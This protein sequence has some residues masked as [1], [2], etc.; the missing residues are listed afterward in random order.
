MRWYPNV[1][2]SNDEKVVSLRSPRLVEDDGKLFQESE[3][4]N[5]DFSGEQLI[6]NYAGKHKRFLPPLHRIRQYFMDAFG[7][8]VKLYDAH[9]LELIPVSADTCESTRY[10]VIAQKR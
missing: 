7:G 3:I 5:V 6:V 9:A 4:V 1:V 8:E 2:Y 10:V